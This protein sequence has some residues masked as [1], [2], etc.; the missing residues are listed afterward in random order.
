M[1]KRLRRWFLVVV[2]AGSLVLLAGDSTDPWLWGYVAALAAVS[3]IA[4]LSMDEDLAKEIARF[5]ERSGR[6]PEAVRAQLEKDNGVARLRGGL[7]REKTVD[8][9]LANA[10]ITAA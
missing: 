2:P 5:A 4:L 3:A 10:S 8:L 1:T 6:T 9:L 7:R